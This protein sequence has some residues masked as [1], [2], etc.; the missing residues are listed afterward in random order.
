MD[1]NVRAGSSPALGT[2]KG[3]KFCLP[4]LLVSIEIW[5]LHHFH[6]LGIPLDNFFAEIT[7]IRC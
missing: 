1:S 5:E 3:D 2:K 6:I 7:E 4:F